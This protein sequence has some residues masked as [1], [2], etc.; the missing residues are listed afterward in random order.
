M[1]VMSLIRGNIDA[2]R[3][4]QLLNRA[5]YSADVK[6]A[7]GA[8]VRGERAQGEGRRTVVGHSEKGGQ[9]RAKETLW[10]QGPRASSVALTCPN[11]GV[12]TWFPLH[13]GGFS[14]IS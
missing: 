8:G 13:S 1:H 5:C 12:S 6:P 7:A 9:G 4:F 2:L 14:A 11:V 3:M 10:N